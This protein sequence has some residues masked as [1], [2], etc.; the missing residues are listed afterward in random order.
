MDAR[1]YIIKVNRIKQ[2]WR[3]GMITTAEYHAKILELR[4]LFVARQTLPS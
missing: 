4:G 2:A 3:R 1:E